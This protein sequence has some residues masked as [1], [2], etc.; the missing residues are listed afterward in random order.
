MG[1]KDLGLIPAQFHV[2]LSDI[3]N[4]SFGFFVFLLSEPLAISSFVSNGET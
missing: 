4:L 3:L 1:L 2:H